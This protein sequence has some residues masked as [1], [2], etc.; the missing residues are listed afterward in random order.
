MIKTAI[1]GLAL[2]LALIGLTGPAPA[3]EAEPPQPPNIVLIV[4]EDMSPRIGAFGD[5]VAVTPVLDAFAEEAVRFPN[6]FTTAGVCAPSRAALMTGHH[7][8]AIGAQHMRT[9]SL[10]G[11]GSGSVISY[12][13]VVPGNVKAFPELLRGA[14]YF[15]TNNAKT[16]YQF[17]TPFTVWDIAEGFS[18]FGPSAP[19]AHW[20]ARSPEQPFFSMI[21]LMQ[22]HE[23]YIWPALPG[24]FGLM[25]VMLGF[26]NW[27]ELSDQEE[28]VSPEDVSVPPYLPDTPEVRQDIAQH[29]NNITFQEAAL[30]RIMDELREDALLEE[31]IIIVTTDHGDGLPRMKRSLYDSGIRVPMMIRFPGKAGAGT[32]DERLVSFVDLAPT[33]LSW[34]GIPAPDHLPGQVIAAA[35]GAPVSDRTYVYAAADRHDAL[36]DR[37]RAIRDHRF[38]Y[39]RN[40]Q[41]D[42][43]F[44]RPLAFRDVQAGMQS[45]WRAYEAGSLSPVQQSYFSAPRPEVELYD[46]QSDPHE[47]NNLAGRGSH[48]ADEHRL[49]TE[50]TDWLARTGDRGAEPE[51]DMV[52]TMWPGLV[53]P[54]TQAPQ[55]ELLRNADGSRE[56]ALTSPTSD[57]SIGYRFGS[58][59]ENR[60]RLYTRPVTVPALGVT[61]SAK[62]IR[63]GYAESEIRELV[64][65]AE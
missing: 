14:G 39:I 29:Y 30:T 49:A 52:A 6:T 56:I 11:F 41:P 8:I 9:R 27:I 2:L 59:P 25:E 48:A 35:D 22:S 31:T 3:R 15:T 26:R 1:N 18:L 64:V 16:D 54:A 42:H 37:Y 34:A 40:Y 61:L 65:D 28:H 53:Q 4:F 55:M 58:D 43:A 44:F 23:G 38:K 62:A 63:Y 46:L 12:D 19:F 20:R 10:P 24:R 51:A 33:I 32:S 57:A 36:P 50:L 60:W 7:Q 45:I 13:A 17:G 21:T 47:I 5:P